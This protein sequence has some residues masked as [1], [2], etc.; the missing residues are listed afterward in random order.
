MVVKKKMRRNN[1]F[2]Q[3][4]PV[5]KRAHRRVM[6]KI[7]ENKGLDTSIDNRTKSHIDDLEFAPNVDAYAKKGGH[8]P[9]AYELHKYSE[10]TY[11]Q[12]VISLSNDYEAKVRGINASINLTRGKLAN[13]DNMSIS[14]AKKTSMRIKFEND[15]TKHE[16]NKQNKNEKMKTNIEL[17]KK[18]TG[19]ISTLHEYDNGVRLVNVDGY[20]NPKELKSANKN[21]VSSYNQAVTKRNIN[22]DNNFIQNL[23]K[24]PQKTLFPYHWKGEYL[25]KMARRVLRYC[26]KQSVWNQNR[27]KPCGTTVKDCTDKGCHTVYV[28]MRPPDS[29]NPNLPFSTF[30][31]SPLQ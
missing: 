21:L 30:Y 10:Y 17:A 16:I 9:D 13:V 8:T 20:V 27:N 23:S 1:L 22:E 14:E 24:P 12:K 2:K 25:N 28:E 26:R 19:P 5:S 7:E 3:N 18:R 11:Q 6:S 31:P 29:K 4:D 15:I